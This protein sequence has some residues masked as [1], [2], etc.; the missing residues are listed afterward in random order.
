MHLKFNPLCLTAIL[1]LAL[2]ALGISSSVT[3]IEANGTCD[4][5]TC[6][7][8][9][10]SAGGLTL[11]NT[12]NGSYNFDVNFADGD[13]YDVSG[14]FSNAFPAGTH[15]GFFPTVTLISGTAAGTDTITLD[16]LQDFFDASA[17]S[18]NSPYTEQI[19]FDFSNADESA[20]GQRFISSNGAPTPQSVG[21]LAAAGPGDTYQ[22]ASASLTGLN[23]NTLITDYQLKFT[24]DEGAPGG[25]SISSPVPEPSQMIPV[26]I[27]LVGLLIFKLR[28]SAGVRA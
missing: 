1:A 8:G 7:S 22:T 10:L 17:T 18:W 4:S 16:M 3:G 24:F 6:T 25:S 27:G 28:R 15:V 5:G 9:G 13:E 14:T 26:A 12:A 23:G 11:G 21:L 19:P 2:P 20:S